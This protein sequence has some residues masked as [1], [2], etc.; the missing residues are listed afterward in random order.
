VA[1]IQ[2][3]WRDEGRVSVEAVEREG[4]M[5]GTELKG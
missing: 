2:E 3:I 5:K 4:E 1:E